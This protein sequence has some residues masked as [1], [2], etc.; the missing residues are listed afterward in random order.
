MRNPLKLQIEETALAEE[1]RPSCAECSEVT[2][3]E[4][5]RRLGNFIGAVGACAVIQHRSVFHAPNIAPRFI[6]KSGELIG[7]YLGR[8]IWSGVVD[9]TFPSFSFPSENFLAN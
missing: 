1:R 4:F 3:P 9:A 2:F 5:I 7:G 8:R 6:R